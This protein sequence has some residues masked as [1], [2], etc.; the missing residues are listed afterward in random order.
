MKGERHRRTHLSLRNVHPNPLP[1]QFTGVDVRLP[2]ELAEYVIE[3]YSEPGDVV[4]DPFAAFGTVPST[5]ERLGRVG[6]GIE[7][8][9]KRAEYARTQ[10]RSPEHLLKA[11]ARDLA[12]L[13]LPG[14]DLV[15]SSPPWRIRKATS[16]AF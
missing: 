16:S 9:E 7:I 15:L 13:E 4:L 1:S 11:D 8:D 10:L 12:T 14:V 6:Y 5:A 2:V 3:E